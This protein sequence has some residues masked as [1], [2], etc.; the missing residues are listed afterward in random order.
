MLQQLL[1]SD[2]ALMMFSLLLGAVVGMFWERI[3]HDRT[4]PRLRRDD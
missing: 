4:N 3:R 1:A 2:A